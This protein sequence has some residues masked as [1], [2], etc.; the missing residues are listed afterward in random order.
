MNLRGSKFLFLISLI[1]LFLLIFS[2]QIF[3]NV[4]VFSPQQR[5]TGALWPQTS[6]T[7]E[8]EKEVLTLDFLTDN[9]TLLVY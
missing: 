6:T 5:I 2:N 8:V 7:I 9:W 4:G 3:A 1:V